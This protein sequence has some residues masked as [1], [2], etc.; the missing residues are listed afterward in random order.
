MIIDPI[1][2]GSTVRAFQV[3]LC[4]SATPKIIK[5]SL[6][7]LMFNKVLGRPGRPEFKFGPGGTPEEVDWIG[8]KLQ[9]DAAKE[10]G[11]RDR[12]ISPT[13]TSSVQSGPH[14]LFSVVFLPKVK[15]FVFV[16]SM[17][18][19][20]PGNFLNTIGKRADGAGG[21]ILLWKRKAERYLID[22]GLDY[23]IVH[24]GGLLDDAGKE[25]ELTVDVDD[26]LMKAPSR[27]VSKAP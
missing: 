10:A 9:I 21:D 18:G 27:S 13:C 1:V 23:T 16:S 24:P 20:D 7:K 11:V 6:V 17:G 19:T 8:A 3:V 5:R 22:S 4:T 14:G 2:L 12:H 15:K 25:R 26:N